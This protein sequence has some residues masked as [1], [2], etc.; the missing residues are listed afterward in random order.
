M[1]PALR[2]P[3]VPRSTWSTVSTMYTAVTATIATVSHFWSVMIASKPRMPAATITAATS[4][5]ATTL[6]RSPSP[7]PS[8]PNT[9]AVA[10][11]A[12]DTRTVS[13]PTRSR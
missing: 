11:V 3:A 1:L 5:N 8:R 6:V 10:K 13:Q 7:Q 12:S 2:S 4:R 9:V